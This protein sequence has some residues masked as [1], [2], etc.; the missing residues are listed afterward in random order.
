MES[1]R[2][3]IADDQTIA[4][5]GLRSLLESV[6]SLEIVGE[7]TNGAEVIDQAARLQPTSFSWICACLASTGSRR[8]AASTDNRHIRILVVTIFE[9]GLS[10]DSRWRTRLSAQGRGAN[11]IAAG[12]PHRGER[13]RHLQSGDCRSRAAVLIRFSSE[14]PR[15][16]PSTS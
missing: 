4:R 8:R 5:R 3:L 15:R 10:G 1:V 14:C 6:S 13:R 11:G 2:I 9:D 12:R 7:A 16:T